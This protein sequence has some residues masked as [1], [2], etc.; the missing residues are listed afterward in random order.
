MIAPFLLSLSM[1]ATDVE[2]IRSAGEWLVQNV[3]SDGLF[4]YGFEPALDRE[5]EGEN[6]VRQ[7]GTAAALARAGAILRDEG[8][9][10]RAR[11]V[12]ARLI[13]LREK[14]RE[15]PLAVR[16]EFAQQQGAHPLGWGALL[17]LG[18]AELRERTPAEIHQGD[19]I[20]SFLLS[21]QR[22]DG[23]IRLIDLEDE[24]DDDGEIDEEGWAY[25]PGEALYALARWGV[26]R[27][28]TALLERVSRSRSVYWKHWR[29]EKEP[30]FIPWQSAA[31]AE[32][33]LAT[34]EK[35][36]ASMVIEMN[37][38]LLGLQY[39]GKN[40]PES[41][42]GGFGHYHEGERWAIEPGIASASYAESLVEG[43]RVARGMKDSV[44]Q[45]RYRQALDRAITFVGRLQYQAGDVKHFAAN[46]QPKLVGAFFQ[47]PFDGTVRIDF[48]QH[49][50][51]AMGGRERLSAPEAPRAPVS[52]RAN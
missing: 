34:G 51:M 11:A 37:D 13:E 43:V 40:S 2:S 45:E 18:L 52:T 31:H 19:A 5:L 33:F 16:R 3:G 32:V 29:Q 7:A 41:W 4:R 27:D 25:Y 35:A 17:L 10:R 39:D 20:A 21:H 50:L 49:A 15:K 44:R 12:L 47:A 42:D 14:D 28:Q 36:S 24:E 22:D 46:Y 9:T 26:I 1:I 38:W 6:L 23:S 8:M 30:A 48:T